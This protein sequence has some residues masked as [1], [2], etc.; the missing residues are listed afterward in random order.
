MVGGGKEKSPLL[1]GG[2]GE[3]ERELASLVGGVFPFPAGD[4]P[5]CLVGDVPACLVGERGEKLLLW[6]FSSMGRSEVWIV[7]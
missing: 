1:A 6:S 3:G 2:C 4:F 7:T 5:P